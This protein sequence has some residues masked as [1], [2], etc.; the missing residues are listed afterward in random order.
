MRQHASA[1]VSIRQHTNVGCPLA[2]LRRR[3]LCHIIVSIRQHTSAYVSIRKHTSGHIHR[4][5][6]THIADTRTQLT[7]VSALT[8][9]MPV[10]ASSTRLAAYVSRRQQ[11]SAYVSIRQHTSAYVSIRQHTSA[12]VSN[13]PHTSAYL[14]VCADDERAR[15][16]VQYAVSGYVPPRQYLRVHRGKRTHIHRYENTHI[17]VCGHIHRGMTTYI[18]V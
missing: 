17:E 5:M 11:T 18:E 2:R 14:G 13:R 10:S 15:E 12:Y 9:S 3:A 1:Y 6:W 4:G 8:S 7:G 16:C